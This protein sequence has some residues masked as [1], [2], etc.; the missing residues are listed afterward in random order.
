MKFHLHGASNST[1]FPV[2]LIDA[3]FAVYPLHATSI[4]AT[5]GFVQTAVTLNHSL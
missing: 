5:R 2:D 3:M 1:G 4:P